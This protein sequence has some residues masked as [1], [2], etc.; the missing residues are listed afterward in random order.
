MRERDTYI[1]RVCV[2]ESGQGVTAK[3]SRHWDFVDRAVHGVEVPARCF[4]LSG[5]EPEGGLKN[6]PAAERQQVASPSTFLPLPSKQ[7]TSDKVSSTF[8]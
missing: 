6:V 2:R 3:P 7:R 5:H 8:K 1:E 4:G